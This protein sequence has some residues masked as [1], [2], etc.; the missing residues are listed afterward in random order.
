MR[1]GEVPEELLRLG[2]VDPGGLGEA[3]REAATVRTGD[4]GGLQAL[5]VANALS[6]RRLITDV[7]DDSLERR[8]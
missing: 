4:Q 7:L 1:L 2:Q 3:L 5:V 6:E 8:R